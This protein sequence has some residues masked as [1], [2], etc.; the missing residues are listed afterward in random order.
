[1][2]REKFKISSTI[3]HLM[4]NDS[5]VAFELSLL[6]SNIKKELCGMLNSFLSFLGK[7]EKKKVH[8]LFFLNLD[9]RF[10]SLFSFIGH[11]QNIS[12]L[13]EYNKKS[14][15]LMLVKYYHHLHP[16]TSNG[17]V[18]MKERVIENCSL[19]A[20]EMHK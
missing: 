4:N 6:M 5:R 8:H 1:M 20:F 3:N 19:N 10:K 13:E 16:L 12:I 2:K 18:S 11:E 9:S 17:N 14:L 15:Y 7:Y